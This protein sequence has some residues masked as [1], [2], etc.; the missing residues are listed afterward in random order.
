MGLCPSASPLAN[1]FLLLGVTLLRC[2]FLLCLVGGSMLCTMQ[3]QELGL[4]GLRAHGALYRL[5]MPQVVDF[6]QDL[7]SFVLQPS[8]CL[9]VGA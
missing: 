4:E 1:L 7:L 2:Q 5:W 8:G 6:D 3:L 9:Q